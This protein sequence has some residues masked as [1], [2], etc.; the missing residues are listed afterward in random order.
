MS[1]ITVPISKELEN[2]IEEE[3]SSGTSETKAGLVRLALLRM[4][5][6]RAL[7]R[8]E[9]AERD[10]KQGRVY[11]GNLKTLLNKMK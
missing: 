4:Q 1:T 3:I 10:I 8:L 9:E 2:F 5:E 6:E 7:S 11:K